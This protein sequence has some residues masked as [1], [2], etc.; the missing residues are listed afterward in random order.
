MGGLHKG[1]LNLIL[2]GEVLDELAGMRCLCP[3][4]VAHQRSRIVW[5]GDQRAGRTDSSLANK[6]KHQT[7]GKNQFH[8]VHPSSHLRTAKMPDEKSDRLDCK[9]SCPSESQPWSYR[10][11]PHLR[12]PDQVF[13]HGMRFRHSDAVDG[14]LMI[15]SRRRTCRPKPSM[16]VRRS[17]PSRRDAKVRDFG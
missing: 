1:T 15:A 8:A 7:P 11:T 5:R 13:G 9:C 4:V 2:E 16:L 6:I 3:T 12:S 10:L 14:Q 17:P